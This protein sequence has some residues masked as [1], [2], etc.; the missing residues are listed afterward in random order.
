MFLWGRAIEVI[1]LQNPGFVTGNIVMLAAP[2][3][4]RPAS[5]SLIHQAGKP[6]L[7]LHPSFLL[8]YFS[9]KNSNRHALPIYYRYLSKLLRNWVLI[10][11]L[12]PTNLLPSLWIDWRLGTTTYNAETVLKWQSCPRIWPDCVLYNSG[13]SQNIQSWNIF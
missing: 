5:C 11:S 4:R 13:R 1:V 12:L 8:I 7:T 3:V 2:V 10:L 9:C 6:K